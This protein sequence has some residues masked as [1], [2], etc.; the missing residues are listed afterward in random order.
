LLALAQMSD[1]CSFSA[2]HQPTFG[3]NAVNAWT[4]EVTP[5]RVQGNALT[6]RLQWARRID[7]GKPTNTPP[8]NV[9]L[10]MRP[11][12]S[13]PLD[14]AAV[15]PGLSPTYCKAQAVSVRISVERHPSPEFDTRVFESEVWL[16]DRQSDGTERT[17]SLIL[18]SRP[19]EKAPFFF[20]A[21]VAADRTLVFDGEL[22]A[23]P[24]D[25]NPE[26]VSLRVD[27]RKHV[28]VPQGRT[29]AQVS[30]ARIG[31][32]TLSVTTGAV[33]SVDLPPLNDDNAGPL[34]EHRFSIRIRT[35]KLR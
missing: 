35:K 20:D 16:V 2:S 24:T 12:E 15:L 18:R 13:M 30:W 26:Q 5:L 9:E 33:G 6:F 22:S 4:A 21:I 23:T 11:G 8:T 25:F 29:F 32:A 31:G 7:S 27:A 3:V 1:L 34:N 10:V 17:Q 28:L 14:G 19:Y